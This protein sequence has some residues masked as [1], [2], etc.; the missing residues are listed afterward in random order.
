M[1]SDWHRAKHDL[2]FARQKAREVHD[3]RMAAL[4]LLPEQRRQIKK[5]SGYLSKN[6]FSYPERGRILAFYEEIASDLDPVPDVEN[7]LW[8]LKDVVAFLPKQGQPEKAALQGAIFW[9]L[10]NYHSENPNDMGVGVGWSDNHAGTQNKDSKLV[11]SV[12]TELIAAGI[13][14]FG[15]AYQSSAVANAAKAVLE[16]SMWSEAISQNT[17]I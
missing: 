1:H 11:S 5:I 10:L 13:E 9:L 2:A 17:K 6:F 12:R 7:A 14:Q 15:S 3:A 8:F 16:S 4:D